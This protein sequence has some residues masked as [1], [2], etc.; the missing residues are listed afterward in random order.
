ML[1]QTLDEVDS[2]DI[3]EAP[4]HMWC[5]CNFNVTLCGRNMSASND[6]QI[7]SIEEIDELDCVLCALTDICPLC[8][9]RLE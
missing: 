8:K 2:T 9:S 3:N 6:P 1:T 5:E 7:V 4:D